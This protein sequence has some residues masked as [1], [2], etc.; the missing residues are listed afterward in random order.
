MLLTALFTKTKENRR[1][2]CSCYTSLPHFR[3]YNPILSLSIPPCNICWL[4]SK[5]F[6]RPL[7]V[8]GHRNSHTHAY[9]GWTSLKAKHNEPLN[10]YISSLIEHKT[11]TFRS[12]KFPSTS[13]MSGEKKDDVI[14]LSILEHKSGE[15]EPLSSWK[16]AFLT[17]P[18]V[19]LWKLCLEAR[20]TKLSSNI[21][22]CLVQHLHIHKNGRYTVEIFCFQSMVCCLNPWMVVK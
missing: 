21:F 20:P 5:T 17:K 6:D 15:F 13:A 14:F 19:R 8:P 2:W 16:T 3:P 1:A 12:D 7:R 11:N 10:F 9:I 18:I 22:N 4:F